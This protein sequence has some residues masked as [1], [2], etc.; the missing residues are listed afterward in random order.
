MAAERRSPRSS[1]SIGLRPLYEDARDRCEQLYTHLFEWSLARGD[2]D[3]TVA[4]Y[5]R[6]RAALPAEQ[7]VCTG[8]LAPDA[9]CAP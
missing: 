7:R 6:Y 2:S 1:R 4:E 5:A 9:S 8:Q 3:P